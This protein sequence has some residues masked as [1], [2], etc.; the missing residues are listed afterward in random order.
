MEQTSNTQVAYCRICG[1]SL[2]PAEQRPAQ[3]TI[4]CEE[5]VPPHTP[6]P[7][8]PDSPWTLPPSSQAPP[9]AGRPPSASPG[10]AF[11]LGLIPGVG[12][13]YNG[14]YA[15]GFIHVVIFGLLISMAS[16]GTHD[17]EPLFGMLIPA[18]IFY[19][20][21]EAYHT[22]KRRVLGQQVDELSS[23]F[24][25]RPSGAPIGP[26]VLIGTGVLF[27]LNNLGLLRFSQVMRFWPLLLIGLGV[28][29]LL[30][31]T[32]RLGGRL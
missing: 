19:M 32:T 31:R 17:L 4:Y 12:A 1:K 22:A 21:F 23:L 6:P 14:Q 2:A 30:Q 25:T 10:L 7:P 27:L 24:A 29:K 13:I 20:A 3:G 5:H 16:N 15:K 28:Y 26:V 11:I 9:N 8:P 18:W